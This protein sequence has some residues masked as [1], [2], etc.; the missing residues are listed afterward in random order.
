MVGGMVPLGYILKA[1]QLHFHE[2]EANVV[3]LIFRRYLEL[4]SVNRLVKD[5]KERGLK[6]KVRQLAS[7]RDL[8]STCCGTGFI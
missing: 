8:C 4:G 2:Q 3:R 7:H 1:G 5:L 6:S